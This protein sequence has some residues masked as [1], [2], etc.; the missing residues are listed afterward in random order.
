MDHG[1]AA[2]TGDCPA[3]PSWPGHCGWAAVSAPTPAAVFS[4]EQGF[5]AVLCDRGEPVEPRPC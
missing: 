2:V 4:L 1:Q 3:L 5:R